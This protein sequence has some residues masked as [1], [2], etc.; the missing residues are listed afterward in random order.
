MYYIDP[1]DLDIPEF[2][3]PEADM[4]EAQLTHNPHRY[5]VVFRKGDEPSTCCYM[6]QRRG[7][8]IFRVEENGRDVAVMESMI[9]DY[10]RL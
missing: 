7:F 8:L 3:K 2:Q 9:Y 10:C 5:A 4:S 6:G 1:F